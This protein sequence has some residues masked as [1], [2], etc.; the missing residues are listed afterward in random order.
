MTK[1]VGVQTTWSTNGA[2]KKITLLSNIMSW[3]VANHIGV[4]IRKVQRAWH[5]PPPRRGKSDEHWRRLRPRTWQRPRGTLSCRLQL[6]RKKKAIGLT[7][8]RRDSSAL[9]NPAQRSTQN[10]MVE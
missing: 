6:D 4:A 1:V 2:E 8:S 9:R 3:D 5:T 10:K 7:I